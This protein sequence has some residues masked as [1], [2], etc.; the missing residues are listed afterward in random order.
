MSIPEISIERKQ[1]L[2]L[3]G[4]PL[5][6]AAERPTIHSTDGRIHTDAIHKQG[7]SQ[8]DTHSASFSEEELNSM[9]A[10]AAEHLEANDVNLKFKIL[11]EN[12]TIQV[13]II[14]S[15]GKTIRKIPGDDFLK[16]AESLKNLGQGFLDKIS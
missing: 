6:N 3:G 2:R 12:D 11:E 7:E 10:E 9:V 5:V 14:D 15:D 1:E 16:L 8:A 13:E 4:L